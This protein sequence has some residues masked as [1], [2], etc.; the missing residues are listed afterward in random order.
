VELNRYMYTAGNPV[1]YRDPSGYQAA[2]ATVAQQNVAQAG[3]A[4]QGKG[5]VNDY[6]TI[7][8][9][10]LWIAVGVTHVGRTTHC[11]YLRIASILYAATWMGQAL[12][13]LEDTRPAGEKCVIPV[14]RWSRALEP[15][16]NPPDKTVAR[17]I[18][19]AQQEGHP[20]IAHYDWIT[21]LF[22][23]SFRSKRDEA[24]NAAH[25]NGTCPQINGRN[26]LGPGGL[27]QQCDEY[28]YASVFRVPPPHVSTRFVFARNNLRH[29]NRLQNFYNGGLAHVQPWC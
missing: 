1:N 21:K 18:H 13:A 25:R 22:K 15:F 14:F 29:G 10:S 3:R 24:V 12:M 5:T 4:L 11:K 26:P 8:A 2:E 16:P 19:D 9:F 6:A 28:P 27:A 23:G 17:H 20:M 7:L